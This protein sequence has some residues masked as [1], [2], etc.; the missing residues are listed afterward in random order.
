[1]T[2]KPAE[3]MLRE[4]DHDCRTT[5]SYTGI[6]AFAPEVMRAMAEVPREAFVPDE[7][8]PWAYENRPLPIGNGQT[9]SQPY[10]VALMTDL[11]R[12]TRN[13]V[14]LEV[15]AGSGYQ[16]AV[17]GRLVK[18]LYTLEIVPTLAKN[19]ASLLEKLGYTNVEV[20]QGDATKG[21]P[22]HAPY[23]GII[24]T[25]AAEQIP[26][27]LI[28]Q[29]KPD[30]RLVIPVG[31][32]HRPQELLLVQKDTQGRLSR[33]NILPVAFVPFTSNEQQTTNRPL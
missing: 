11:L 28:E 12:P 15:G 32:P 33:K 22:E 19:A 1:M 7:L 26:P 21:W 13:D 31:A 25:A 29:L 18:K 23:D 27:A 9:I 4:I 20:S 17:L 3:E 30:G 24:V 10:I 14:M 16:A 6:S 5:S 2:G 8:K